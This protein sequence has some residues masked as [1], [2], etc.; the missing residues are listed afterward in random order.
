MLRFFPFVCWLA[1]LPASG[2]VAVRELPAV[3]VQLVAQPDDKGRKVWHTANFRIDLDVDL[4]A[5]ELKRIAQVIESTAAV[6][7]QHPLPLFAPPEGR[8]RVAIF[9]EDEDYEEAGAV[10]GT[11]GFYDGRRECVM[12]RGKSLVRGAAG[13]SRLPPVNDEDLV[14]H[15]LVHL[16]MHGVNR[17]MPQW[18]IE[19]TAEY[20]ASAHLG[21]G[22]FH[23][24]NP[25]MA[26]REHLRVRLSPDRPDLTLPPLGEIAVLDGHSW[27]R[28]LG[29]M[30]AEDRYR[31]YGSALLLTHYH[32][33]GGR[34]RFE[35]LKG[36]LEKPMV[37]GD[38][39]PKVDLAGVE[40]A[41]V[42]FWKP[43]GLTLEFK[44]AEMGGGDPFGE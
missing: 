9:A 31:A 41:L 24:A 32:L 5:D 12:I 29:Q 6:I 2:Q 22:R 44:R 17:R 21:A 38:A 27:I 37:R 8:A 26:V 42:R 23:F 3:A 34:E 33:H 11:A 19:G 39:V 1:F 40:E 7:R 43:K 35:W 16:C 20:F 18:F 13:R 15:E 30:R 10:A 4:T 28:Y 25:E 14:V 36:A